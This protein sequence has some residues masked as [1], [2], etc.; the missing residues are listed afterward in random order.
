MKIRIYKTVVRPIMAYDLEARP[1][2][3]RTKRILETTEIIVVNKNNSKSGYEIPGVSLKILN[4]NS[5][6][7]IIFN[8]SFKISKRKIK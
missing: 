7:L 2:I 6:L 3:T 8:S 1:T 5:L 4:Y